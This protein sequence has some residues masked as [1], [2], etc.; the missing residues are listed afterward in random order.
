MLAGAIAR[1]IGDFPNAAS[2][3]SESARGYS[4]GVRS[5]VSKRTWK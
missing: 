5:R 4:N 2:E 3:N 1:V